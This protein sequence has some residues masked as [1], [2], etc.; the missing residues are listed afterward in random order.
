MADIN[1]V[2]STVSWDVAVEKANAFL[3]ELTIEEKTGVVTGA[4][5]VGGLACIG[6]IAPIPRLNFSGICYSDGA[7]GVG[8]TDLTSVFPAGLTT[9]A[10][11]DADM[12][13]RRAV[14]LGEE[15]RAK[16]MHAGLL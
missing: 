3:A 12:M 5:P 10:T 1:T 2:N 14:A 8:R 6:G 9:A 13:Y 4:N 15:F 16:G 11:W 7:S